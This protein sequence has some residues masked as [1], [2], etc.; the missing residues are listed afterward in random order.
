MGVG[1]VPPG[2][3]EGGSARWASGR[4]SSNNVLVYWSEDSLERPSGGAGCWL[5][6][7]S[8]RSWSAN[9]GLAGVSFFSPPRLGVWEPR[10]PGHNRTLL[11]AAAAC[12]GGRL[13]VLGGIFSTGRADCLA[14]WGGGMPRYFRRG[15]AAASRGFGWFRMVSDGLGACFLGQLS[16]A[17]E[18]LVW[19]AARALPPV[20]PRGRGPPS[21]PSGKQVRRA[22]FWP[23]LPGVF[24]SG[25]G[26]GD[27][28]RGGF[29]PGRKKRTCVKKVRGG[30]QLRVVGFTRSDLCYERSF[31]TDVSICT[32]CRYGPDREPV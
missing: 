23:F 8:A 21:G 24:R 17:P 14:G 4:D 26:A 3:M 19:P 9:R 15:G 25:G 31:R 28:R 20:L 5:F 30:I 27:P 13:E 2:L 12:S 18:G 11:S 10:L 6:D 22:A 16:A 32:I 29:S 1:P 7:S